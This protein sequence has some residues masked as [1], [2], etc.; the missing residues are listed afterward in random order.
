[1]AERRGRLNGAEVA[2]ARIRLLEM[3]VAIE[4][5]SLDIAIGLTLVLA[6]EHNLTVYD[7]AY[8]EIAMR[9]GLPLATLDSGL[10]AAAE[11]AGVE[12]AL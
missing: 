11:R 6:R 1:M 8:L 12:L 9:E 2:E 3:P 5:P 7:A 4:D 10:R